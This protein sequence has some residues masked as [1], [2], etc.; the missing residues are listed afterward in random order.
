MEPVWK[1]EVTS[2]RIFIEEIVIDLSM[3]KSKQWCYICNYFN[4]ELTSLFVYSLEVAKEKAL[5]RIMCLVNREQ[6]S[7][8]VF[9]EYFGES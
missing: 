1:D 9:R 7:L 5:D 6:E 2:S 4:T 3:N 8:N